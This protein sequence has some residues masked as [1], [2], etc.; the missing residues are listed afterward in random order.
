MAFEILGKSIVGSTGINGDAFYISSNKQ[1]ILLADGA[2]GAGED[3]KV[4]MGQLCI[5]TAKE[6]L[7]LENERPEVFLDRLFW[8]INNRLIE[9]SQKRKEYV[10]GTLVIGLIHNDVL[11]VASIGDSPAYHFDGEKTIEVAKSARRYESMIEQGHITREQYDGYIA[12]MHPWMWSCFNSFIPM[13]VPNHKI[14]Q[15]HLKPGDVFAMCCDGVS[16]W[17][18]GEE[19]IKVS[20]EKNLD[21]AMETIM[22]TAKQRSIVDTGYFDDLTLVVVRVN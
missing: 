16:D 2:S 19:L 7:P 6:L 20:I 5:E 1:L 13:V 17:V 8:A 21:H 22:E 12:N 11:T 10:F 9:V 18:T 15:I 4:L 3:G 14:E